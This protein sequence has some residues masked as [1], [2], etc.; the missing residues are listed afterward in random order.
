MVTQMN[1]DLDIQEQAFRWAMAQSRM[2][3]N[4]MRVI[5]NLGNGPM[6]GMAQYPAGTQCPAL[7]APN[8]L[9]ASNASHSCASR[10]PMWQGDNMKAP[11]RLSVTLVSSINRV[12]RVR[13]ETCRRAQQMVD[14]V[15][16][17]SDSEVQAMIQTLSQLSQLSQDGRV[18][19]DHAVCH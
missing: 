17:F 9:Q 1:D 11:K 12:A 5:A 10:L 6:S 7:Q 3:P 19:V 14:S 16:L 4:A 2:A 13:V 15:G 8:A 18:E